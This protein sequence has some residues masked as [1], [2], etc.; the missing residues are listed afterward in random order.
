[1]K[2]RYCC[3]T[4]ILGNYD[5]APNVVDADPRIEFFLFSDCLTAAPE[6]WQLVRVDNYFRDPKITSGFLKT[7]PEMLFEWRPKVIWVDGN[8]RDLKLN[9]DAVEH[10]LAASPMASPA[11]RLRTSVAEELVEVLD[12]SLEHDISSTRLAMEMRDAGF[13]D[14]RGLSAT[15]L[16]AR[17]LADHR[18]RQADRLWWNAIRSGARRDQIAFDFSVWAAG[19][20]VAEIDV[21]WREP[22]VIFSRRPH[23]DDRTKALALDK[24]LPDQIEQRWRALNFPALPE[25]YPKP[26]YFPEYWTG[27]SL[28]V[29][30]ELN[31]AAASTGE[32]LEGNYCYFHEHAVGK[33]TPPDPRRSWKREVLRLAA[34]AGHKALEIGFNAGH[35]AAIMLDANPLLHLTSIDNASHRY[36]GLCK[37]IIRRHYRN[38]F[39]FLSGDSKNKL[40]HIGNAAGG[41]FDIIHL[42]GGHDADAVNADWAWIMQNASPGCC[43][44]VDDAYVEVIGRLIGAALRAGSLR[45]ANLPIPCSGENRVFFRT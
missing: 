36:T 42:D 35:S 6:P 43:I 45:P 33:H 11:H 7:N 1:M 16:L 22:N 13:A 30:H 24:F 37:D 2:P 31:E 5:Q 27:K 29:I 25:G 28:E 21:D 20:K 26:S 4:A 39:S 10:W 12:K 9:V 41:E 15:M 34:R 8:L 19:L 40:T 14:D 17:D 23:A 32:M 44:I 38:R 18:V 3:Y